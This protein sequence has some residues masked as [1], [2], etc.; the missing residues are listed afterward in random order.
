MWEDVLLMAVGYQ[1]RLRIPNG[2]LNLIGDGLDLGIFE[3][4]R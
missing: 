2:K 3:K 1:Q 4:S